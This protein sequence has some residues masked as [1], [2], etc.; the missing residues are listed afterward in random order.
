MSARNRPVDTQ[1]RTCYGCPVTLPGPCSTLLCAFVEI[2]SMQKLSR[3]TIVDIAEASGVSVSTVSR[4]LNDKPDVAEA[5]R[6]HVL[7]V[8]AARGYTRQA[9]WQQ[10]AAGENQLNFFHLP[11]SAG[12]LKQPR[13]GFFSGAAHG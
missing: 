3:T 7:E 1:K 4:I 13:I 11:P 12:G 8:I 5:T 2:S 6:R 9:Q 10:L